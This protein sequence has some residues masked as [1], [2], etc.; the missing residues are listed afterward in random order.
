LCV[1]RQGNLV[2]VR[3]KRTDRPAYGTP[4]F[5]IRSDGLHY[6]FRPGSGDLRTVCL[7]AD[8]PIPKRLCGGN[9]PQIHGGRR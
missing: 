9:S 1:D 6:D 2:V 7:E 3:L 4:R 8:L 5:A